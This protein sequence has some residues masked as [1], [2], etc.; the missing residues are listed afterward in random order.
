MSSRER[1]AHLATA[2]RAAAAASSS[3]FILSEDRGRKQ[4]TGQRRHTGSF[5]FEFLSFMSFLSYALFIFPCSHSTGSVHTISALSVCVLPACV[6]VWG[7]VCG[8]V[9]VIQEEQPKSFFYTQPQLRPAACPV[10]WLSA[11][12]RKVT[13][14]RKKSLKKSQVCVLQ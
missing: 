9:P 10:R 5:S 8:C 14:C 13:R 6:Y 2:R 3:S 12:R 7:C 4:Q 11:A 1:L